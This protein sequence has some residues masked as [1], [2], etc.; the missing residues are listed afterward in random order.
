LPGERLHLQHGPIDLVIKATGHDRDVRCAYRAACARFSTVLA[1]LTLELPL[2]RKPL[3][4]PNGAVLD[5]AVADRTD[6]GPPVCSSS[7]AN[8][9][10]AAC[11][12]HRTHYITPM[13]AVAGAVADE[14][15]ATMQAATPQLHTAYVNNGG[16]MAVHVAHG[17]V[18]R[19]GVVADLIKAVPEGV[20]MV[21][22]ET[23]IGGIA[24]SGWRGRS[25]SLGIADA[26]TVLAR[27]AAHADAAATTIANAVDIDDPAILR[28]AAQTLDPDSD[29]RD[30]PVTTA[31]GQLTQ[32]AC[33]RALDQGV[34]QASKL[35][36]LQPN[37]GGILGAYLSLQ[38]QSRIV[39]AA[40]EK[41]LS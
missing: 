6:V 40:A 15:L 9:M 22:R 8:R 14:I 27:D 32:Q 34:L 23:G 26:V 29:L 38:G 30:L 19:I 17:H 25:F 16:D 37:A 35:L 33:L 11:W 39:L 13:A 4:V 10:L 18:L 28:A 20:I 36:C 5:Q 1:E 21:T 2:L 7:T 41:S 3:A 31:V 24:T 12:P